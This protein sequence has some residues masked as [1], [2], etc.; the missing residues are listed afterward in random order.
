MAVPFGP[1]EAIP[2]LT[3]ITTSSGLTIVSTRFSG[4]VIVSTGNWLAE[5]NV[6]ITPI[7]GPNY[8][9]HFEATAAD[10]IHALMNVVAGIAAWI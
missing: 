4:Y 7:V 2:L 1:S 9:H 5:M 3:N 8:T 10:A 6:E